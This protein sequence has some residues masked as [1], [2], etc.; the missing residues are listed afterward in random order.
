[1]NILFIIFSAFIMLLLI[2]SLGYFYS[3]FT[4]LVAII[5]RDHQNLLRDTRT[6]VERSHELVIRARAHHPNVAFPGTTARCDPC[7]W[8]DKPCRK[9]ITKDDQHICIL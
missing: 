1:M 9:I 3:L 7:L 2:L 5:K 4:G 8:Q 6:L